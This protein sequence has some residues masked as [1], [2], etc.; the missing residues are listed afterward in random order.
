[1]KNESENET[2]SDHENLKN[3]T[4]KLK[5]KIGISKSIKT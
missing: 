5:K 3:K 2:N 1:M 4:K